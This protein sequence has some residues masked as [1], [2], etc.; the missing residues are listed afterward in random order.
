M[1]ALC[2]LTA[3]CGSLFPSGGGGGPPT[4]PNPP[5]SV[6]VHNV[7]VNS[8]GY[9]VGRA[10]VATVVLP[11]GMMTLSNTM[12]QVVDNSGNVA[13]TCT[14]T[15]PMTDPVMNNAVYYFADFSPFD[16]PG[17]YTISV[18]GLGTGDAATSVPFLIAP[19]AMLGPLT[20]AMTGMTGQRCGTAVKISL[21]GDTWQHPAC[22]LNDAASLKYLTGDDKPFKSEGGWHDAGDFGKYVNNGVFA[23][24]MLLA[25][26][27]Q[28]TPTL[29]TLTLQVPEHGKTAD[30]GTVAMPD[31]LWEIKWELDWLLTAQAASGNGSVP[32]K[33]TALNFEAFGTMPQSDGQQRYF[34]GVGTAMAANFVAVMAAAARIYQ[35]YAPADAAKYLAAAQ[36]TYTYLQTTSDPPF[37]V[38]DDPDPHSTKN[39]F[40]TGHYAE[41]DGDNRLWAAAEMWE[42]TGDPGALADIETRAQKAAFAADFDWANVQ[43]LGL[44]TYVLSRRADKSSRNATIVASLTASLTS[45]ADKLAMTASANIFG[46]AI[47]DNYYWGSNG[48]VGRTAMTLAAANAVSP[49]PKYLDAIQMQ[50]DFLLGR[51][52]YDRS[53]VTMVGYRPPISPHHGPSQG[54]LIADPWPGLVVGG[55]NTQPVTAGVKPSAFD[56]IDKPDAYDVNEIAINWNAPFVFATAALTP[57]SP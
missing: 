6:V 13:W 57:P 51:N 18:P 55:A 33:L 37:A 12:A 42:T 38:N 19:D 52:Y 26:W 25:A 46:R 15:G 1:A 28:F 34:S 49:D 21:G 30:G 53:Q 4:S 40:N 36:Q 3:G 29:A 11:A 45:T 9:V 41:G 39:V 56:W 7:R 20:V 16:N 17:T 23:A 22:H 48:S 5:Q 8:V 31:F 2:G 10:K 27:E 43:N 47:G 54:D 50:A 24:G 14:M 44:Y 35:D 32:D